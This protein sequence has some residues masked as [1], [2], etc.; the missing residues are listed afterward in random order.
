[1]NHWHTG[2]VH[3]APL[4]PRKCPGLGMIVGHFVTSEHASGSEHR[5]P[6]PP[7]WLAF[8]T[9]IPVAAW[10]PGPLRL[11]R[12][13]VSFSPAGEITVSGCLSMQVP[14][15]PGAPPFLVTVWALV[16]PAR[17]PTSSS[18]I[19]MNEPPLAGAES[20]K[21]RP[22]ARVADSP[23]EVTGG[24]VPPLRRHVPSERP[25][26]G[27]AGAPIHKHHMGGPASLLFIV[28]CCSQGPSPRSMRPR[29]DSRSLPFRRVWPS[30]CLT[31]CLSV[32][33]IDSLSVWLSHWLIDCLSVCLTDWLTVCLTDWMSLCL[34]D[35]LTVCMTVCLSDSLS[36]SLSV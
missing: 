6:P 16:L 26:A 19:A 5:S 28:R 11:P 2:R 30:L 23:R 20:R 31:V 3:F 12:P 7:A 8:S 14:L 9:R 18:S 36:V 22:S 25:P 10:A 4:Q 32:W 34:T 1:M 13:A 15:S 33:L 29:S 24:R 35:Y 27:P 17:L 21:C